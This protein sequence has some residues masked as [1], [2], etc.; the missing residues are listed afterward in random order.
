MSAQVYEASIAAGVE[1]T[2]RTMLTPLLAAGS[3]EHTAAIAVQ[4]MM[5]YATLQGTGPS[6][7]PTAAEG[8]ERARRIAAILGGP[9]GDRDTAALVDI[10]DTDARQ[11]R[12]FW[13]AFHARIAALRDQGQVNFDPPTDEELSRVVRKWSGDAKASAKLVKQAF[14]GYSK[15]TIL[16]EA[17]LSDG[18][19]RHLVMRRDLPYAEMR[20]SV[21]DEFPVIQAVHA[22]GGSVPEPLHLETDPTVLRTPFLVSERA[23]GRTYGTLFGATEPLDFDAEGLIGAALAD[24]HKIDPRSLGMTVLTTP[25][26]ID[27]AEIARIEQWE[28]MYRS[29]VDVPMAAVEIGLAWLRENTHLLHGGQVLVHGDIGF[30]N[31]MFHEG[32]L[33]ALLDWELAHVGHAA[34]DLAYFCTSA[35]DQG[36]V[37][38]G[39]VE[40]GGIMPSDGA[41]AYCRIFAGLRNTIIGILLTGQFK[42]R[43]HVDLVLV[44]SVMNAIYFFSEVAQKGL[45]D[46]IS[47]HGFVWAQDAVA[48]EVE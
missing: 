38:R 22:H 3:P 9:A 6:L 42:A 45:Q 1:F 43:K 23:D 8:T 47:R 46:A 25:D 19:V 36:D 41:M 2:T 26:D 24:L 13:N 31:I 48:A 20:S 29:S 35:R 34:E 11:Y 12:E 28:T 37:I 21:I 39:F 16:F 18:T 27:R 10:L 32:R 14:G 30:H 17:T 5:L 44:R 7:L 33:T 4:E 15:Q 40:A